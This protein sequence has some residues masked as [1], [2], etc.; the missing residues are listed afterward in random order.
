MSKS[1]WHQDRLPEHL[2]RFGYASRGVVYAIVG[3]LAALAALG[4]AGRPP[5]SETALV[6]LLSQPFGS[7]LLGLIAVGLFCFA[8]W[9]AAQAGLDAEHLGTGPKPLLRR[10]GF[11]ASAAVNAAL[12]FSAISLL[13][14]TSAARGTD[15]SARDWTA[16][17]LSLPFGPALVGIIG[18]IVIGA[19]LGAGWKGYHADV[20]DHLRADEATCAWLRPL[21]RA[22]YLARGLVLVLVGGFLVTA[23]FYASAREARGLGGSLRA[24]QEQPYGWALLLVTALGLLAFGAFQFAVARYGRIDTSSVDSLGGQSTAA[25]R[26]ALR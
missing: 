25:P 11:A 18:L 2:A 24:L 12:A 5:D 16:Y 7:I 4:R 3:G 26:S 21:G 8:L 6:T 15:S 1:R 14:H 13:L 9:R 20:T 23:A 10:A 19:G 22:G 17:L